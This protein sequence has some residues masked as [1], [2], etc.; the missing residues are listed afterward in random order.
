MIDREKAMA[1][2]INALVRLD[3]G[4]LVL[5][6]AHLAEHMHNIYQHAM[7]ERARCEE[8]AKLESRKRGRD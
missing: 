1:D 5:F 2:A 3:W 4:Q 8:I 6:N 7:L